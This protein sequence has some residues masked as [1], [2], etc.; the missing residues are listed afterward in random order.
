[1]YRYTLVISISGRVVY[2]DAGL[3]H[4]QLQIR[5]NAFFAD[6]KHDEVHITKY[7]V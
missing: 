4:E 5:L 2:T 6:P 3:T 1:V 7:E